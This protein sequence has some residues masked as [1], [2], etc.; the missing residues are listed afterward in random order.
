L[1]IAVGL[2]ADRVAGTTWKNEEERCIVYD[3]MGDPNLR[4]L[5][6]SH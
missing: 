3:R 2:S 5:G 1:T 6:A 4:I